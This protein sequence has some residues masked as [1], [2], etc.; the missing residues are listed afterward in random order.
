[1]IKNKSKIILIYINIF[2]TLILLMLVFNI[3]EIYKQKNDFLKEK[4]DF[5]E[6]KN[7]LIDQI[8]LE[9]VSEYENEIIPKEREDA[10][11]RSRSVIGGQFSENIAP[12]LPNFPGLPTEYRSNP[13]AICHR[14]T[15]PR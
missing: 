5:E 13:R 10:R 15:P 9:I 7:V 8:T 11:R 12:Y 14:S 2:L 1:M 4:N 3:Q 6:Y